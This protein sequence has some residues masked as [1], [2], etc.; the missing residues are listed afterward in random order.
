MIPFISFKF[1]FS[2]KPESQDFQ[3]GVFLLCSP[4]HDSQPLSL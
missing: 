3:T 1:G 2:C 4:E